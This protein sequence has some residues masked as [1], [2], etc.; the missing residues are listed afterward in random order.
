VLRRRALE[1]E[2]SAWVT[3][4]PWSVRDGLASAR[5]VAGAT[6][7]SATLLGGAVRLAPGLRW[8]PS[9]GRVGFRFG[10]WAEAAVSGMPAR[11]FEAA[12]ITVASPREARPPVRVGGV[13]LALGLELSTWWSI[14]PRP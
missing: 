7:P 12:R 4:E 3:G 2:A 13:E 11:G 5:L 10:A 8:A 1:L 6:G 9:S 14:G